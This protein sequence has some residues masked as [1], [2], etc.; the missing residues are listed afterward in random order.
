[1]VG[2]VE[3]LMDLMYPWAMRKEEHKEHENKITEATSK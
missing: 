1:M 2:C 3:R